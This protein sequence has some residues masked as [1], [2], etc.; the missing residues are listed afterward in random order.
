MTV[1]FTKRCAAI[2][3]QGPGPV[4]ASLHLSSDSPA[5][6]WLFTLQVLYTCN[7]PPSSV[8]SLDLCIYPY[9]CNY[10]VF[11]NTVNFK[12]RSVCSD[13]K[14]DGQASGWWSR[15]TSLTI[16]LTR[17]S[18]TI[19]LTRVSLTIILTPYSM[20]STNWEINAYFIIFTISPCVLTDR[21]LV[22]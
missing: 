20:S 2:W 4:L 1:P 9:G 3:F 15:R 12:V 6:F 22:W 21:Y 19:T 5:D 8:L 13:E 17:T 16:T 11:T 10:S 14:K 18:L 7:K